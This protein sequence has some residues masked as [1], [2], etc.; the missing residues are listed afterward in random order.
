[1]KHL[2]GLSTFRSKTFTTDHFCGKDNGQVKWDKNKQSFEVAV[3][4]EHGVVAVGRGSNPHGLK[5]YQTAINYVKSF[6]IC[7]LKLSKLPVHQNIEKPE[8]RSQEDQD[9]KN[10][11]KKCHVG[12]DDEQSLTFPRQI[13]VLFHFHFLNNSKCY[14]GNRQCSGD[15][16]GVQVSLGPEFN[17]TSDC[18][19]ITES[20]KQVIS[21]KME[22]SIE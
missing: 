4:I 1:M 2:L 7:G 6:F 13:V 10:S 5:A 19:R 12:K 9:G 15:G 3:Q 17:Q 20:E 8:R 22:L 11:W 16:N 21:F 14:G 18:N